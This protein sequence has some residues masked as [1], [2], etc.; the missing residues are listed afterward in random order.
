M[1]GFFLGIHPKV[2]AVLVKGPIWVSLLLLL[3]L[4]TLDLMDLLAVALLLLSSA[5][6]AA[7]WVVVTGDFLISLCPTKYKVSRKRFRIAVMLHGLSMAGVLYYAVILMFFD[8]ELLGASG[9]LGYTALVGWAVTFMVMWRSRMR[10][11]VSLERGG[12]SDN[13]HFRLKW[14]Q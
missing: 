8:I 4:Y 9:D 6:F 13:R 3:F 12:E 5:V 1:Q 7:C 14:W 2:V 11:L 10:A